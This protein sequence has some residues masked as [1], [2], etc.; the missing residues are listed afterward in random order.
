MPVEPANWI[1]AVRWLTVK[2]ANFE[3]DSPF[4]VS[5]FHVHIERMRI[6]ISSDF[7]NGC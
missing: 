6:P 3:A 2:N 1:L 5:H 7:E 4:H